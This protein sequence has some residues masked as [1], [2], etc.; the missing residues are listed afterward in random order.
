MTSQESIEAIN[1]CINRINNAIEKKEIYTEEDFSLISS[2][3]ITNVYRLI[4]KFE[5]NC[6][7]KK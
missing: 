1:R 4:N 6:K 5:K 7:E 3:L 2:C